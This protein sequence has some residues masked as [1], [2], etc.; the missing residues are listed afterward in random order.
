MIW[1]GRANVGSTE[2]IE[3]CGIAG[4]WGADDPLIVQKMLDRL[5]HRGPDAQGVFSAPGEVGTLGHRRLSIVD[6]HGGDQPLIAQAATQVRAL[7]ANGEIYNAPRLRDELKGDQRFATRSD[8]E[9][10]LHLLADADL[11]ATDRLRGMFAFALSRGDELILGRDPIGIKPLYTGCHDDHL[12]FSSELQAFPPGT[13]SVEP[14]PPGT[15]WSSRSGESR[16][17]EIP[18]PEPIRG[19]LADQARRVRE[20]LEEAVVGHL[21][22]DVEV[23]AFLSGGL[24][25]SAIVALARQHVDELHTFSVGLAGSADLEAARLVSQHLDTIH[26]EY[27]LEPAE[28]RA[29]LPGIIAAL[30]SYDQDLVRS[31]VPTYFTSR[32]AADHLKVVLTGEGADELFAGYR[33]HKNITSEQALQADARRSLA[34]LHH[35]N[36]QRVDRLTMAHALEARVPFLDVNVIE[37]ALS[38]PVGLRRPG[39][40]APEKAVLRMAVEDLLP[41]SIVW[42][43][44]AQFD[45]GSGTADLLPDITSDAIDVDRYRAVF[46][47]TLLRSAEECLYHRLLCESLPDPELV[48]PNVARWDVRLTNGAGSPS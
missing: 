45:E 15:V 33:Y 37:T 47:G 32:L 46:P 20:A 19:Q 31:A 23:G 36:L 16:Y 26:H 7:V 12:V 10:I 14:L 34:E 28:I 3:M 2:V 1:T 21:M 11:L 24:D 29:A 39:E 18:D 40:A 9:V 38:I 44:K 41:A 30:E 43:D 8:S 48:L 17:Y 25:S 22:S 27:V 4:T 42:R 13:S 5:A 6:V 35:A